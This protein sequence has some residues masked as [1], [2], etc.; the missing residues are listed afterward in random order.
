M[1]D[2]LLG[3]V[4][5][6]LP[7]PERGGLAR[8]FGVDP[9]V[10]SALLGLA[11]LFAGGALV[12][13]DGMAHFQRLTSEHAA[14][15]LEKV[16]PKDFE[17]GWFAYANS[18]PLT[19]LHWLVQPWTWLLISIPVVGVVRLVAYGV[20]QEASGEPIVWAG[21]RLSQFL[22]RKLGQSRDLLRF[23]PERPDRVVPS[24]GGL[25]VL[26]CRPKDWNPLVTIEIRE[27]FYK[28]LWTEE[29]Q[30]GQ[31]WVYAYVLG[32]MPESEVIRYLIRY[33]ALTPVPS[34]A[35]PKHTR[36]GRGAPPPFQ[37]DN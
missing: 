17:A 33:E 15:L 22:G 32:E 30:D 34:P 28:L 21:V 7:A 36:P 29:R 14:Y 9:A 35:P 12:F 25:T 5:A 19:V 4:A 20:S 24:P 6:L 18:G 16:D 3:L 8:R 1:R 10:P 2:L 31:W 26:S 27:R 23:G 11:E 37:K 13:S